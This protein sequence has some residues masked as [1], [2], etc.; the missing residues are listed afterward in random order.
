MPVLR[1][2]GPG[3]R[4]A[5]MPARL[6]P[7]TGSPGPSV[8]GRQ[9]FCRLAVLPCREASEQYRNRID[10][11]T[12]SRAVPMGPDHVVGRM[13]ITASASPVPR[14]RRRDRAAASVA[15]SMS[16]QVVIA[17]RERGRAVAAA[18]R[19]GC[20]MNERKMHGVRAAD[21]VPCSPKGPGSLGRAS[22]VLV[23]VQPD[24]DGHRPV[25]DLQLL[26]EGLQ[27]V[28]HRVLRDAGP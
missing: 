6:T 27:V 15:S 11:A 12:A 19:G 25:L 28:F 3:R 23:L 4:L 22:P 26:V 8:S 1:R 7:R 21:R 5:S 18:G 17:F 13:S 14:R 20:R 9:P 10:R 24:G 16:G 2:G